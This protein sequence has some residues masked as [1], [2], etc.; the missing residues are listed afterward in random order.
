[1]N[2]IGR[3]RASCVLGLR[4]S[5]CRLFGLCHWGFTLWS[6]EEFH[7]NE[8]KLNYAKNGGR[9]SGWYHLRYGSI[10]SCYF[11]KQVA[12]GLTLLLVLQMQST[13]LPLARGGCING[14]ARTGAAAAREQDSRA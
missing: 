11:M 4:R 13:R 12:R 8:G 5:D 3:T 7:A 6:S 2:F 10:Q 9:L 14:A 1:M